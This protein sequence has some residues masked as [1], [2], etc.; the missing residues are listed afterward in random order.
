MNE[1]YKKGYNLIKVKFSER[2]T[3]IYTYAIKRQFNVVRGDLVIVPVGN[4]TNPFKG[5]GFEYLRVVKVTGVT[6]DMKHLPTDYELK[7][8]LDVVGN[9]IH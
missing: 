8:V 1:K 5:D 7:E 6:N 3:G 2:P 9:K 4:V